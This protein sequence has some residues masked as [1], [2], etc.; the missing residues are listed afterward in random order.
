MQDV[1]RVGLIGCGDIAAGR[2]KAMAGLANCRIVHAMDLREEL[3]ADLAAPTSARVSTDM[4]AVLDDDQVD[5]VMI[6]TPH[7][8][9]LSQTQAAAAAGK[10]V[11]VEKPLA[12][13][14]AEAD[15]MI[16]ACEQA[17]VTLAV[18]YQRRY[19][20]VIRKARELVRS[21]VIGRLTSVR[22][23]DCSHKPNYYW[24]QG[25]GKRAT[26]DWRTRVAT[27]GGGVLLMNGSHSIDE[28]RYISGLSARRV[29]AEVANHLTPAV[30]VEDI[31]WAVI[32]YEGGVVGSVLAS[33]S[34][35]GKA[36]RGMRITGTNGQLHINSKGELW[37]HLVEPAGEMPAGDWQQIA[38]AKNDSMREMV[39]AWA[40]ALLAGEPP[41]ISGREA[42]PA[43]EIVRAAYRSGGESVE[44]PFDDSELVFNVDRRCD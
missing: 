15:A 44:I 30:E 31:A 20:A 25:W 39:Q 36:D 10:H 37:L 13:T 17:G 24:T 12:L 33:S 14:L 28:F 22:I 11:L 23:D 34:Y 29:S 42:R 19:R 1:V 43:M 35:P 16:A 18:S 41:P 40:G 6:S 26:T 7:H 9:H 5:A 3:A 21:G 4:Q 27:A 38:V 8:L 2:T 32:G